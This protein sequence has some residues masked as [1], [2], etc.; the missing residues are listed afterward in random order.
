MAA[1]RAYIGQPPP[2]PA[3]RAGNRDGS[4][5]QP[6][7]LKGEAEAVK[8]R[9]SRSRS[10]AEGALERVEWRPETGVRGGRGGNIAAALKLRLPSLDRNRAH[11]GTMDGWP[12]WD[13]AVRRRR[14]RGIWDLDDQPMPPGAR[15][16]KGDKLLV[17]P[18]P[19]DAVPGVPAEMAAEIVGEPYWHDADPPEAELMIANGDFGAPLVPGRPREQWLSDRLVWVLTWADV[20]GG[21]SVDDELK[22]PDA[23]WMG[24]SVVHPKTGQMLLVSEFSVD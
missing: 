18:A 1:V 2:G 15:C 6:A 13:E 7:R 14:L 21:A 20:R 4:S 17:V 16:L 11:N 19:D 22:D 8:G 12:G 10:D 3:P 24:S 9:R 5:S 23:V